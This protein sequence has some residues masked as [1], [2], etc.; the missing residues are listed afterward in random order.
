MA[1]PRAF[2]A[3]VSAF[4][5]VAVAAGPAAAFGDGVNLQPSYYADGRPAIG[6]DLMKRH[7]KIKTV[8]FEI[9]PDK[10]A[11]AKEWIAQAHGRGYAVI[12]T[13]HKVSALGSDE[14]SEL[15]A[16]ADWWRRHYAELSESGPFTV[17][18]MNEWGSHKLSPSAYSNAYNDAISLVR[19]V[20]SGPI[21]IDVP[22]WGQETAVAADA[23]KGRRGAA[24]QDPGVILSVHVYPS[25]YNAA[26]KRELR[27]SDLDDLASAGRPCII[28]EFGSGGE[29]K[30]DWSGIVAHAKSLGWPVL[31]WA[32]NGDGGDMNMAAPS[33]SSEPRA[34]AYAPGPYFNAIYD[35]LGP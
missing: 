32:W 20:Y 13:Y 29:G 5:A 6:W 28:G 8:R 21:I 11:Q 17:N 24:I 16:A 27:A 9:E 31:G 25:G 18:L 7:K 19:K 2:C 22:G 34:A 30:A 33:W 23:V 14:T 1:S 15:L 4:L 26:L 12:A 3:F 35:R 10:A